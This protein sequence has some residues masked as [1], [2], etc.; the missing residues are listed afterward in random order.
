M[1]IEKQFGLLNVMYDQKLSFELVEQIKTLEHNIKTKQSKDL[2]DML[3]EK[4]EE[5][6]SY[7]KK[8]NMNINWVIGQYEKN[9]DF[10]CAAI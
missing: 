8:Y 6:V 4:I 1:A 2:L 9:E 10:M 7:C 5:L 3:D